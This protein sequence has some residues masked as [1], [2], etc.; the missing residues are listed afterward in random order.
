MSIIFIDI[1]VLRRYF[2]RHAHADD[3]LEL[4][5][6]YFDY[7]DAAVALITSHY[8]I[9]FRLRSRLFRCHMPLPWMP[10][11]YATLC[12]TVTLPYIHTRHAMILLP[13]LRFKYACY[14]IRCCL[15][16]RC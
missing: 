7:A 5:V 13:T 4:R 8:A 10:L 2:I 16:L 3:T 15:M 12:H 9:L 6:R 11:F 1:A 14:D